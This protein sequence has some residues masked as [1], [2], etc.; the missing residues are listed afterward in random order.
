MA[1]QLDNKENQTLIYS[2][3]GSAAAENSHCK[4]GAVACLMCSITQVSIR[5]TPSHLKSKQKNNKHHCSVIVF[6]SLLKQ[7]VRNK[8]RLFKAEA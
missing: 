3:E 8:M 6:L 2:I 1:Y 5:S 7:K 4:R